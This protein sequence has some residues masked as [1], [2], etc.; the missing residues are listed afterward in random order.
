MSKLKNFPDCILTDTSGTKRGIM[1][2]GACE[3][4]GDP[5]AEVMVKGMTYFTRP[6]RSG[7]REM[8]WRS[9]ECI[10]PMLLILFR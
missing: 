3:R 1:F 6:G 9:I 8:L 2:L 4:N 10:I 7:D 5:V